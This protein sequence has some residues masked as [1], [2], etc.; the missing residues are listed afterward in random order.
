MFSIYKITNKRNG[1]LYV[2]QTNQPIER[3]FLQHCK[4]DSPLGQAI[5]AADNLEDDFT[6]EV[7]ETCETV[8]QAKQRERFWIRVLKSKVPNGY[9]RSNGG[10]SPVSNNPKTR[11]PTVNAVVIAG[12]LKRFR[13]HFNQTQREVAATVDVQQKAYSRYESGRTVPPIELII[14][15]ADEYGVPTDY[16]LGR[17]EEPHPKSLP[18]DSAQLLNTLL[19]CRDLIQAT[20]DNRAKAL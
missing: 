20:L 14:K 10:E 6:I 5:R 17:S 13:R 19:E 18:P 1:K 3:R 16:L 8:E 11:V 4:A 12:A 15:L 7:V 2:G 9:N